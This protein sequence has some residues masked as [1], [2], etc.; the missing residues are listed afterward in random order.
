MRQ[1]P[2]WAREI[3]TSASYDPDG[4]RFLGQQFGLLGLQPHVE[5]GSLVV[6]PCELA[7]NLLAGN[8]VA[9]VAKPVRPSE[10]GRRGERQR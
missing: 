9:P 2:A 1:L 6:D 3:H 4:A 7:D 10:K 5:R 8:P